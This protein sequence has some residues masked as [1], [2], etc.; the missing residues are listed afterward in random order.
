LLIF[1][2]TTAGA[3]HADAAEVCPPY[4]QDLPLRCAWG[5]LHATPAGAL[6]PLGQVH[7]DYADSPRFGMNAG[8]GA[9]MFRAFGRIGWAI[10]ARFG[11]SFTRQR[12]GELVD[13]DDYLHVGPELRLGG[14]GQ[15]FFAFGLIRGGYSQRSGLAWRSS[16]ESPLAIHGGHV[17]VGGG[18][19]GHLGARFLV[20]GELVGDVLLGELHGL[21]PLTLSLSLGLWL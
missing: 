8:L 12:F 20:G 2:L 4:R 14:V 10:G 21:Y 3:G 18:I 6:V 19:W 17:G 11:Y 9:G 16:E 1:A 5:Y 15:R 7:H 13:R